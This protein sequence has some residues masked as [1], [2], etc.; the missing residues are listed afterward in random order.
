VPGARRYWG[1][2][3]DC[4]DK[5]SAIFKTIQN[6]PQNKTPIGKGRA[7]V[8]YNLKTKTLAEH[9]QVAC[10][11]AKITR[12]YYHK[13]A[14]LRHQSYSSQLVDIL[15]VEALP[16]AVRMHLAHM[17]HCATLCHTVHVCG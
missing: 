14:V 17:H 12:Q 1:Y 8:R 16:H 9:V 7:F 3:C 2:L 15:C 13:D 10:R 5:D 6:Q 11:N 4:L